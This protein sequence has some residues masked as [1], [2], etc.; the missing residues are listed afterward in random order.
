MYMIQN[1]SDST[2]G[3]GTALSLDITFNGYS[4]ATVYVNGVASKQQLSNG[5]LD[6]EIADAGDAIFVLLQR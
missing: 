6:V 4:T 3:K 1:V 2:E 5:T